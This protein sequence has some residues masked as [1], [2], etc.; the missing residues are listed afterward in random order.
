M[1]T[2]R[3]KRLNP[4]AYPDQP[5]RRKHGPRGYRDYRQYRP[6]L[7][8]EFCYRC[9]Y[10]L[11][12]EVWGPTFGGYHADHFM[13]KAHHPA[14][15]R[16]Y[17]NLIYAC[18][19][20]NLAKSTQLIPGPSAVAYGKCLAVQP[21]G[22]LAARDENGRHLISALDLNSPDFVRWRLLMLEIAEASLKRPK[23]YRL[24][25]GFPE[26]LEDLAAL[27]EPPDGNSRRDGISRS[28]FEMRRQGKLPETSE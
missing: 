17:D 21:S 18:A 5:H 3:L 7:R 2:A 16:D 15:T 27:G 1:G 6:W 23:L 11:K 22:E 12:R 14:L 19:H 10:C 9:A 8:D 20:C 28:Y 4:F 25:F 13:P 24:A 26:N